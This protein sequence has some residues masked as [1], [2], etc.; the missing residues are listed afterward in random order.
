MNTQDLQKTFIEKL[1]TDKIPVSVF[2]KNGVQ[3]KGLVTRQG[4]YTI[5][6]RQQNIQ[7]IYKHTIATILP[8]TNVTY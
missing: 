5:E 4:K 3:L 8:A 2:L 6:L 7:L 1:I